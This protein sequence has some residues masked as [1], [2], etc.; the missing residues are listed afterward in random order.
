MNVFDG[1][2]NFKVLGT[3][4]F[5][6]VSLEY[7]NNKSVRNEIKARLELLAK[8]YRIMRDGPSKKSEDVGYMIVDIFGSVDLLELEFGEEV[9]TKEQNEEL[10]DEVPTEE[11]KVAVKKNS[12]KS[13]KK[14]TKKKISKKT[15]TKV[16]D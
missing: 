5:I 1:S 14:K 3:D 6:R 10:S 16:V 11:E 7:V 13:T 2:T 4:Q 12:K 15:S 9:M 8:P